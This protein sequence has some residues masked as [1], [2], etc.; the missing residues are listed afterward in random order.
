MHLSFSSLEIQKMLSVAT[1][2]HSRGQLSEAES[3]YARIL[4]LDP[5]QEDALHLLGVIYAQIGM[6][7]KS[8]ELITLAIDVNCKNPSYFLNRGNAL[9]E[10]KEYE[11]AVSDYGMAI[12]LKPNYPVAYSNL[13]NVL[14]E[15]GRLEEA[16]LSY[17]KAIFF[18]SNYADAYYNKGIALYALCS[19]QEAIESYKKALSFDPGNDQAYY[20][21]GVTLHEISEFDKA[22]ECYSKAISLNNN[23]AAAYCGRGTAYCNLKRYVEAIND[24][25][26]TIELD[27]EYE[28]AKGYLLHSKFHACDWRGISD[29]IEEIEVAVS[30][31]KKIIDPFAWQAAS[32]AI[33]SLMKCSQIYSQSKYISRKNNGLAYPR[34]D[35]RQKIRV[36]YVSGEF[37]DQATSHLLVSVLENHNKDQF[38]I[39]CFDN[40]ENDF[41]ELRKRIDRSVDFITSVKQLNDQKLCE[42]IREK[43]IDVLVNLNGFFGKH[44]NGTFALRP[45]PIQINYLGFPGTMGADF[46]DYIIADKITIPENERIFYKEKIIYLPHS[47][48]PNDPLRKIGPRIGNRAGQS[49]PDDGFVFCCF[50][51]SYKITPEIFDIW[52]NILRKVD[53]SVL[54]LLEDNPIASENLRREAV[55]RQ[56]DPAR[57]VF[58]PR[59]S[60]SDHLARHQ[61]ADLF[62]D[63]LPCNAHTTA[64]DALWSGLP[65]LTCTGKTFPGRVADSLLSAID[66]PELI[67]SSLIEYENKAVELASNVNVILSIRNRIKESRLKSNLYNSKNYTSCLES[68]YQHVYQRYYNGLHPEHIQI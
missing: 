21:L 17:D 6:Y 22:I 47:Y 27:P 40:G 57:L 54:W 48:Q 36:G 61:F 65:L 5:R 31:D 4:S 52:M 67:T 1:S 11:R 9:F 43:S 2:A 7:D 34:N 37:G 30:Q 12:A 50:N 49:L 13:G 53:H 59:V 15:R 3:I 19:F 18:R 68:A 25:K 58:A 28:F 32:S 33:E 26:K 64:S 29:M 41:S 60:N 56:I 42:L 35:Q 24:Y 14:K 44:R 62:L 8:V 51:N 66:F 45:A 55:A 46:I 38:E 20:N 16:V 63:T 23:Y 10:L 39:F